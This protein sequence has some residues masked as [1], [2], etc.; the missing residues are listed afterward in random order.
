MKR[1]SFFLSCF[2]VIGLTSL[3]LIPRLNLKLELF[4]D[5]PTYFLRAQSL[6]AGSGYIALEMPE[7]PPDEYTYKAG[8]QPYFKSER[9]TAGQV[10]LPIILSVPM[11]IFGNTIVVAKLTML[12]LQITAFIIIY[13]ALCAFFS[14]VISVLTTGL[15]CINPLVADLFTRINSDIL[16]MGISIGLFTLLYRF[17]QSKKRTFL[18]WLVLGIIFTLPIWMRYGS[19]GWVFAA[20][21]FLILRILFF[22]EKGNIKEFIGFTLGVGIVLVCFVTIWEILRPGY[23]S[24][25]A[26]IHAGEKQFSPKLSMLE[27]FLS[28]FSL[29]AKNI[30]EYFLLFFSKIVFPV[31][32]WML[33]AITILFSASVIWGI[34]RSSRLE[35]F[36]FI[37]FILFSRLP[38]FLSSQPGARYLLPVFII[39]L[40]LSLKGSFALLVQF[41]N[42]NSLSPIR[43]SAP[44]I[45]LITGIFFYTMLDFKTSFNCLIYGSQTCYT[46][47][48]LELYDLCKKMNGWYSEDTIVI[49][50][51]MD[52]VRLYSGYSGI[53]SP[54]ATNQFQDFSNKISPYNQVLILRDDIYQVTRDVLDPWIA[55]NRH[56]LTEVL[57]VNQTVLYMVNTQAI[58]K[59]ENDL[60]E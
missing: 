38:Y 53:A 1:K 54:I 18:E 3:I 56:Y 22:K 47:A 17:V 51:K 7:T 2:A 24:F 28:W 37:T 21:V 27:W 16:F 10:F 14:P 60:T 40:I 43:K 48:R 25:F 11:K 30:F 35:Q 32:G 8:T 31:G 12:C 34:I 49:S 42:Q 33:K 4:G 44:V 9:Q 20:E 58:R 13:F 15:I 41:T 57:S 59:R 29:I 39:L 55:E 23:L 26:D 36:L 50:R 46:T 6:C 19:L 52:V 45:I 5:G